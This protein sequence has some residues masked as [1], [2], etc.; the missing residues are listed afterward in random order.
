MRSHFP[1][2]I[3]ERS[4]GNLVRMKWSNV[5]CDFMSEVTTKDISGYQE[6][7]KPDETK[8]RFAL[9][10]KIFNQS[11]HDCQLLSSMMPDTCCGIL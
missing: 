3:I 5:S 1:A 2:G 9:A 8:N 10:V 4:V 6:I 7:P 11:L